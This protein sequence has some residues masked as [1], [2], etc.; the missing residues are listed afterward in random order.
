MALNLSELRKRLKKA[1]LSVESRLLHLP[2][3]DDDGPVVPDVPASSMYQAESEEVLA[4]RFQS[5]IDSDPPEDRAIPEG[6]E[7]IYLRLGSPLEWKLAEAFAI[8]QGGETSI[9]FSDGM[10]AIASAVGF[11]LHAGAEL[12]AGVPLYG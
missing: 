7:K 9:L 10:R 6:A 3:P 4:R 12:V 2:D 5:V 11:R 8:A 1:P